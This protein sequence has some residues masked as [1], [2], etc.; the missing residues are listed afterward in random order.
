MSTEHALAYAPVMNGD[1]SEEEKNKAIMRR[2]FD[3]G[4]YG[5]ASLDDALAFVDAHY[6]PHGKAYGIGDQYLEGPAPFR[7]FVTHF[8]AAF[9]HRFEVQHMLAEGD[10]VFTHWTAALTS[11]RTGQKAELMGGG[12]VR[13]KDGQIIEAWNL[14]NFLELLEQ[15]DELAPAAVARLFQSH[16][17]A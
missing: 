14:I 6:A 8:L 9:D 1:P 2:W 12:I 16:A 10:L 7:G 13:M 17:V 5:A 11:R 4:V 15:L 3:G